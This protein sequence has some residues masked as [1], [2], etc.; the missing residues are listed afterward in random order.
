MAENKE[1]GAL[2]EAVYYILLS[3]YKPMHGYAIM[4]N[5]TALSDGRV[6]LGAGTLYGAINTLVK[7]GWIE[8][9]GNHNARKKEYIISDLGKQMIENEITRL[10]ELIE[11]GK[12]VT[13]GIFHG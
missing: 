7:K 13:G 9:V 8:G 10:T 5:I 2:T 12:N 6:V 1:N 11:N 3:V 4:Q